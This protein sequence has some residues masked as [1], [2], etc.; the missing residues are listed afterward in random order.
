MNK[1]GDVARDDSLC[2]HFDIFLREAIEIA[3][4]ML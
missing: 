1:G 2:K 4:C 3:L